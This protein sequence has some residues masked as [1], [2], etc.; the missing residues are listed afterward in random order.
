[1]KGSLTE[2]STCLNYG[3]SMVDCIHDSDKCSKNGIKEPQQ[4]AD[5]FRARITLDDS[6]KEQWLK[7]GYVSAFNN[8]N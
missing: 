8:R 5:V 7:N 6:A 2:I 3:Y 4:L 1:M